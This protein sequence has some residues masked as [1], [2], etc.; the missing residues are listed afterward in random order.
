MKIVPSKSVQ[1]AVSKPKQED[2]AD[3]SSDL[4]ICVFNHIPEKQIIFRFVPIFDE[5]TNLISGSLLPPNAFASTTGGVIALGAMIAD[6]DIKRAV[7][8]GIGN[9]Q[10]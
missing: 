5:S 4:D 3:S 2:N 8:E 7:R 9:E 10:R 6:S 1:L